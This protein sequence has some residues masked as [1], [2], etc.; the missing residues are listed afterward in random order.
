MPQSLRY[1]IAQERTDGKLK[2]I[3]RRGRRLRLSF[4]EIS[5]RLYAEHNV[6]VS[7]VTLSRW[8]DEWGITKGK[9]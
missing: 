3:L 1:E 4:D 5:R 8:A 9:P 2:I 6:T 7:P